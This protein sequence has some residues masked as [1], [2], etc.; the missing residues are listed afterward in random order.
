MGGKKFPTTVC[1]RPR[2]PTFNVMAGEIPMLV[3]AFRAYVNRHGG[4][5][6]CVKVNNA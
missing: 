5:Q 3:S 2:A 4:I 6:G 1:A